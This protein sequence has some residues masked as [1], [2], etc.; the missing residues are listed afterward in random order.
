[1]V[2]A[3][4]RSRARRFVKALFAEGVPCT[5]FYNGQP[6]YMTP[7]ILA[8]QTAS[9]KGGPWHCAE[10][11]TDVVL[12][13][14]PVPAQ[15]GARRAQPH[16]RR[17]SSVRAVRLRGR[18]HRGRQGRVAPADVTAVDAPVRVGIIGC[19]SIARS[20][21]LPGF[22]DRTTRRVAG[23]AS[24]TRSSAEAAAEG[25]SS[26]APVYD[27]WHEL[28][29]RDDVD[30]VAICSPERVPPRAGRGRGPGRQARPGREAGRASRPTKRTR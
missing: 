29:E 2:P 15:R 26:S 19:G 9:N 11:P 6:V 12:R 24:R 30:A 8:K 28:L 22:L 21:H 3:R 27:D 18:R 4:R 5:Q 25:C 7:H 13:A 23:F 1:M 10:H 17:G 14:R 16:D 20:A